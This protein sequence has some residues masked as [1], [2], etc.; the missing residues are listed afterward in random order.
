MS[1]TMTELLYLR[2]TYLARGTATVRD[3]R[4]EGGRTIVTL[5]R[6][7]LYPQ[8]GGQPADHGS[9]SYAGGTFIVEDVRLDETG[10]VLHFGRFEG[11]PCHAG[12]TVTITVDMERRLTNARCHSAGHL[13]DIAILTLGLP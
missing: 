1:H 8:G 11:E 2:D 4:D 7:I 12:D 13:I 5:D 9:L 6:T 3:I 10:T